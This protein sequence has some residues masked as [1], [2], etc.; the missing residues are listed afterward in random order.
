MNQR[1]LKVPKTI[2][3]AC[4]L[5]LVACTYTVRS[6]VV[7]LNEMRLSADQTRAEAGLEAFLAGS[8]ARRAA[9]EAQRTAYE[10]DMEWF[11]RDYEGFMDAQREQMMA[12]RAPR[13]PLPPLS[14]DAA[15]TLAEA[16][17]S[18]RAARREYFAFA[19]YVNIAS[20]LAALGL[21]GS[22]VYL[23]MNDPA[24][25][26]WVY[27]G[28]LSVAF[29]FLIGPSF[30]TVLSSIV[31]AMNAPHYEGLGHGYGDPYF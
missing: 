26:R 18:F 5:V 9:Y 25:G 3:L 28:V 19:F 20:G 14:P 29:V 30:H 6:R 27:L 17:A 16:N 13:P 1:S 15:R 21:V 22:L 12:P 24:G 23:A 4:F 7:T 2:A 8:E 10:R 11:T 31:S